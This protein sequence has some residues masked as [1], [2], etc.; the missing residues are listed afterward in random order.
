MPDRDTILEV[1]G[2]QKRFGAI[3]TAADLH[4]KF[5]RGET[6]GI[7][8]ANGAGKTTF[9]NL[10]TG[11]L[12]PD[13]G[14]ITYKDRDITGLTP[15]EVTVAG[16]CRSFQIPQV[17]GTMTVAENLMMA[18]GIAEAG[19]IPAALPLERQSRRQAVESILDRYRIGPY[20][21]RRA[22]L[23]PQGVRKLLD[24]AMATARGPALL[25]LDEPT[26]GISAAEKYGLMDVIMGA[27]QAEKVTIL[28]I[29]HDM[30]I[31]ARYAQRVLAF[32][33]GRII[34]D[35]PAEQVLNDALVRES[36]I[37]NA[38][39]RRTGQPD[40]PASARS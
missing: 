27:L 2:L 36:V 17:F 14:T 16:L 37:G 10:I 8:G 7:I 24:I 22:G 5:E 33:A 21:D 40:R 9:V 25:M 6:V 30:E 28:F 11:Y 23:L 13:S 26:S 39:A 29:E 3:V 19:W 34:A 20:H 4:V 35:G 18:V 31:V 32:V 12:K 15:R 38:A 1:A